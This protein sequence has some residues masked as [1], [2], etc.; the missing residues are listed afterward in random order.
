MFHIPGHGMAEYG[1]QAVPMSSDITAMAQGVGGQGVVSGCA[2]SAQLSPNGTL[3]V[4]AGVVASPVSQAIAAGNVTPGAG[5]P[6]LERMD[7]IVADPSSGAKLVIAGT[8]AAVGA[9]VTPELPANRVL[10]AQL[11]VPAGDTVFTTSHLVDKRVT[12]GAGQLQTWA[13]N[14]LWQPGPLTC[15]TS[16]GRYSTRNGEFWATLHMTVTS[17][18]VSGN[19]RLETPVTL[20]AAEAVGGTF[21]YYEAGTTN[22][23]GRLAPYATGMVEFVVDGSG[24]LLGVSPAMLC[25][26]GDYIQVDMHGW[27]A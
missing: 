13:P 26:A 8:P 11:Y 7:L 5:H 12:V 23:V 9:V 1:R 10:L 20:V 14:R 22:R 21:R 16:F 24:N 18:G 27:Y 4:A 3:A 2:V 25:A 17:P 15:T 19:L 6:S